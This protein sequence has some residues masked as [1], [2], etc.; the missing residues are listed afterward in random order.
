MELRP[1]DLPRDLTTLGEMIFD[2]FQYLENPQWSVQTDEKEEISHML[3]S[4][5]RIW[6]LMRVAQILAPSLRDMFRG[7]VALEDG[8]IVGVTIVQR[9]GRRTH[10]L[11]ERSVFFLGTGGEESHAPRS[12]SRS[13]CCGS[14]GRRGPV[15]A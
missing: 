11:W 10:G 13:P 12:K 1:I 2:T 7:Y 5:R 9:M 4:F 15:L 14:T 8:R 3:K 6:P